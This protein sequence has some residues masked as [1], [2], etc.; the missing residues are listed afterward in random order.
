[1]I[2]KRTKNKK[3]S[4]FDMFY[5][6]AILFV[7]CI[8]IFFVHKVW[9]ELSPEL[10]ADTDFGGTEEGKAALGSVTSTING[11]NVLFVLIMVFAFIAVIVLAFMIDT[12]PIMFV[13][14]L[15]ILLLT[16]LLGTI[17]SN[18]FTEFTGDSELQNET[19]TF[20]A[21]V[22]VMDN[23]PRYIL[24]A[25]MLLMIIMYGRYR[26]VIGGGSEGL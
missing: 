21:P 9:N 13:I 8:G 20:S 7:I 10:E 6:C 17:F 1:M 23:L 4:M 2:K 14:A 19:N 22:H 5:V 12:H 11:F 18:M 26:G 15:V 3:G 16:G 24:V 25:G